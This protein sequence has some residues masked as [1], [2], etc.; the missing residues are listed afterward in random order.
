MTDD[1]PSDAMEHGD[2]LLAMWVDIVNAER[3]TAVE[4]S[5][6]LFLGGSI[7]TGYLVSAHSYLTAVAD[8]MR[9]L[10]DPEI[11]DAF[12]KLAEDA[13]P[14][15]DADDPPA[16][17]HVHLRD[18]RIF[19]QGGQMIPSNRGVAFRARIEAVDGWIHGRLGL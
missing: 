12:R 11:S 18:A 10:D 1:Q 4:L 6:T 14:S 2:D 19:L 15:E 17:R 7:V 16:A 8:E 3:D 9:V 13:T 5:I